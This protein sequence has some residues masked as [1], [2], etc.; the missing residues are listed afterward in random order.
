MFPADVLRDFHARGIELRAVEGNL[1]VHP[2][3]LL[4]DADRQL[5][6]TRRPE[7][8]AYLTA[9]AG[10]AVLAEKPLPVA[11][12]AEATPAV[13]LVNP[14]VPPDHP[15]PESLGLASKEEPWPLR[16][17]CPIGWR[18][19]WSEERGRL[20]QRLKNCQDADVCR[21][22]LGLLE[23]AITSEEAFHAW[24][25]RLKTLEHDLQQEGKLPSYPWPAKDSHK[26]VVAEPVQAARPTVEAEGRLLVGDCVPLLAGV[27][28]GSIDLA[29]VDPPYN[30]GV[31]YDVY[32]D[33]LPAN[34]YLAKVDEWLPAILRVLKRTGSLFVVI[35]ERWS[36]EYRLRLDRLGLAWRQ[37]IIWHFTF[38]QAQQKQFTPSHVP[39]LYYVA[40]PERFTFN[41]DAVRVPSAR[42]TIYNDRRARAGG[43]VP[44]SVWVLRPQDDDRFFQSESSVWYFPRIPGTAKDRQDHPCQL[45]E[46]LVERIILAASN[47]G[48]LVLD[49]F[50]GSGT[51]LEVAKRLGRRY[52]GIELSQAYANLA[53]KRLE[54]VQVE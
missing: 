13:P 6:R 52:L 5:L 54:E 14:P 24:G 1:K 9:S 16:F 29:V 53:S 10:T 33:K 42:Q 20:Q 34:Q 35:S 7:L 50:A 22:I 44:D 21:R 49:P 25:A 4:T 47:P 30:I 51:T 23:E 43:K 40:D 11:T 41:A 18:E 12:P 48:D 37:N 27:P 17:N 8:L 38:G 15:R 26:P 32:N 46:P 31:A 28:E 2:K 19:E 3:H 45:P 36:H 39:I